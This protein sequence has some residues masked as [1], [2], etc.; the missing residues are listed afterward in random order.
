MAPS[1]HGVLAPDLFHDIHL[2]DL[3]EDERV[4]VIAE[5][6]NSILND[7]TLTQEECEL[8]LN[9]LAEV[10]SD[11]VRACKTYED[12]TFGYLAVKNQLLAKNLTVCGNTVLNNLIVDGTF[13][14]CGVP[15]CDL[16]R[17]FTLLLTVTSADIPNTLVLRDEH[18][19]FAATTITVT[20]GIIFQA[21]NGESVTLVPN[22][23][24]TTY[25]FQLPPDG[26]TNGYVLATDGSGNTFWEAVSVIG[27]TGITQ[28]N[29]LTTSTQFFAVGT[30]GT[31]F[32]IV[33][34]GNTHTFNIP[35]ASTVTVTAGTISNTDYTH[36]TNTYT[37]VLA[38]T[39][40]DIPNTLVLRDNTGSFAATNVSLQA[41][42]SNQVTLAPNPT[43]ANYTFQL[44][45]N[46]GTSGYFLTTNGAGVT[47][48]QQVSIPPGGITDLNGLTT[49][50]QFFA[51][52]TAGT[53]FNIVSSGNTHTFNIPLAST[54]T[55]TAG[56][57]SNTDY[58][59][60]INTYTTVLAATSLDVANTLV[61]RDNTGSFAATNVSL[62]AGNT[63]QVTLAPNP[64]TASYTLQLPV[65]GGSPNYVLTTNGSG[66]TSWQ[67]TAAA[68][69]IDLNG[70]TTSTQF[71]AVGTAGAGFNIVSSGNTHTFN[72]PLA[73]TVTVTAGLL[74]N[75]DYTNFENTYLTVLAAT[76]LDTPNTLVL[77][78]NTGSFA[79]T[80]VSLQAG[81]SNQVTL[82]P[83]GTTNNYTLQLPGNTGNSGYVLSTDGTGV[84]SWQ[85]VSSLGGITDLNNLSTSTQF[86]ANGYAGI[87]PQF[88]SLGNT[89]TL[90]IPLASTYGVLA[91][92]I[93]STDYYNF[94][95]TYTTVLNG[96]PLNIPNTLVLRDNTG[97][98]AAQ[99]I[100]AA[101]IETCSI[102][103]TCTYLLIQIGDPYQLI[104]QADTSVQPSFE[105]VLAGEPDMSFEFLARGASAFY[106]RSDI[107]LEPLTAMPNIPGGVRGALAIDL[108]LT[109]TSSEQVASGIGSALLA[110]SLNSAQAA[111]SAVVGGVENYVIAGASFSAIVGGQTNTVNGPNSGVFAGSLHIV[112]DTD[113]VVLGGSGSTINAGGAASGIVAGTS[114]QVNDQQC[115]ILGGG[116]N[117]IS[118]GGTYSGVLGGTSNIIT[119]TTS[120]IIG[121]NYN[122]VSAVESVI[123]GGDSNTITGAASVIMGGEVHTVSG[124]AAGV[125]A[126]LYNNV[127][128]QAGVAI[129]GISN[130]VTGT[131]TVIIGGIQNTGSGLAS[132][133]IGGVLNLAAGQ[134][135]AA[136]GGNS[137]QALG[138]TS[139]VLGGQNNVACGGSVITAGGAS[140]VVAGE[141]N[142]VSGY[143]SGIF[144]GTNNIVTG[145]TA[146]VIGGASNQ[147]IGLNS[148]AAGSLATALQ[149]NTFVWCDGTTSY[150]S[151][152]QQTFNVQ[153]TGGVYMTGINGATAATGIPVY[154]STVN[155]KLG[156]VSSS[157]R[158]KENIK[159]MS[160]EYSVHVL[161]LQPMTFNYKKTPGI[162]SIGLIAED[163]SALFPQLVIYNAQGE[164]ETVRYH[165]LPVLLLNEL[166]K[167]TAAIQ[168]LYAKNKKL[169]DQIA[170]LQNVTQ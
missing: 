3:S 137:N 148:C 77:R 105:F 14:I 56:T 22:P 152:G 158:Y 64:S 134:A 132:A 71:F 90:N 168:D 162:E 155:G 163:V 6:K 115:V 60:F 91:G 65:T 133:M 25:T 9:K 103:S 154:V 138:I 54:V 144:V 122:T 21:P 8:L 95:R 92:L 48:W 59:H 166:R 146:V 58:T 149:N 108:Q 67:P 89:H 2:A 78:D 61:L 28:L 11:I 124:V 5:L 57:I 125:F 79:A 126:G 16:V 41:G 44:P 86:F 43:T 147:A 69:I 170:L 24:T 36:F 83:N 169:E 100:T 38:A 87:Q 112:N 97:S 142:N 39:P 119:S 47:S 159:P 10:D 68:G 121:G 102:V 135:S 167:A 164:P 7:D 4:S 120:A 113:S 141:N 17:G 161:E 32:N 151:N 117:T 131:A 93:S 12:K 35:L 34:S 13:I 46:G 140:A 82:A 101:T 106:A 30:A 160:H 50:T 128:S 94:S 74:S 49:S 45:I 110:G 88:V 66:I 63:N 130:I 51:V 53:G 104:L 26:G 157:R 116:N 150:T 1:L 19:S 52:G 42:N 27:A 129:G 31:G 33:S 109:R 118:S 75:A 29:G 99:N 84:T 96:T 15:A 70:L 76:S 107:S 81:N 156:T 20:G 111:G 127:A 40:L 114:N 153:A 80:N 55:V 62:Q 123:V 73:S 145:T 37:T 18:G 136:V 143:A 139:V 23:A 72:I 165:D 98:F 85:P